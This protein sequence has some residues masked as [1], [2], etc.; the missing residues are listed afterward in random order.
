M[1]RKKNE[2]KT[3][4]SK[5]KTPKTRLKAKAEDGT[6]PL[7]AA[8]PKVSAK[9]GLKTSVKKTPAR[10]KKTATV[11]TP[12]SGTLPSKKTGR[13]SRLPRFG[14][15]Q[16]VAFVRDPNCIFTY[17]EVTPE[18]VEDVKRQLMHEYEGSSMVLRVLK[19]KADGTSELVE[20]IIVDRGEMNRYVNLED[21]GGSYVLEIGHKASSGRFV[22]L[23]RTLPIHT[24]PQAEYPAGAA[25][26]AADG[27]DRP[28]EIQ[29]YF[30]DEVIERSFEPGK[31]MFSADLAGHEALHRRRLGPQD[32]HA[33]SRF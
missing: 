5:S 14:Q 29:E 31:K 24:G 1:P 30:S 22:V 15:T 26:K 2:E 6:K 3:E 4:S 12:E 17:W 10:T 9:E 7:K 33:A 23:A 21:A 32:R 8:K 25:E 20:E 27:W 13:T 19:S 18:S 28:E 16:L 11:S